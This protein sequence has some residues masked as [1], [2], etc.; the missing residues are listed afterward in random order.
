M[1]SII[2]EDFGSALL[3]Q[4]ATGTG[5]RGCYQEFARLPPLTQI[6]KMLIANC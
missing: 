3:W 4:L 5:T 1:V 2:R 6:V